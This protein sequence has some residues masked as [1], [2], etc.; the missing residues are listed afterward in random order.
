MNEGLLDA[1][2]VFGHY[3]PLYHI[4]KSPPFGPEFQ[5]YTVS[6]AV[7]RGNFF[8][9]FIYSPWP[10]NPALKP[11]VSLAADPSALVAAV[12]NTLLYGRMLPATRAAILNSLP[13]M[14][15]GNQRVLS[16]LYLTFTSGEY[17][18]QH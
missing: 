2:S 15:D 9:Y 14:Y 1:P 4:P 13:A 18:V 10:L 8:Y 11:L 12:D 5:I 16:A 7:N 17:L 6:D 3:S